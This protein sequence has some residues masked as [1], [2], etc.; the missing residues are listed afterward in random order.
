M[1]RPARA[2]C[3]V[4]THTRSVR[5]R[6]CP[7]SR[8]PTPPHPTPL[9]DSQ[10]AALADLAALTRRL[11]V[12]L[13]PGPVLQCYPEPDGPGGSGPGGPCPGGR[14][15]MRSLEQLFAQAACADLFL[16]DKVPKRP[17]PVAAAVRRQTHHICGRMVGAVDWRR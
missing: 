11:Q 6:K 12:E 14:E 8:N 7:F 9:Q 10:S 5:P 4:R 2:A 15:A 1:K 16:R 13:P 17:R 3:P